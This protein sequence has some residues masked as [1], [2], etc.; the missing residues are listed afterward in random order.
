MKEGPIRGGDIQEDLFGK[1][2]PDLF[3]KPPTGFADTGGYAT[4][5]NAIM[6]LPEIVQLANELM[7]GKYPAV[8]RFLRKSRA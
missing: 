3:S 8:K 1:K 4:Q 2:E 7:Q 6:E 5:V